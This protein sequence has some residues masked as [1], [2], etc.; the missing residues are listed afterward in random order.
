MFSD[1]SKG[2]IGKKRVNM[3]QEEYKIQTN[4]K[5]KNIILY[6]IIT[7]HVNLLPKFYPTIS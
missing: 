5:S 3:S 2:N 4:E 6:K 7:S 1:G